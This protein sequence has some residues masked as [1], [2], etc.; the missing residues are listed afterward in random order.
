MIQD[1]V[2]DEVDHLIAAARCLKERGTYKVYVVATHGIF[3]KTAAEQLEESLIDEVRD[4]PS[5]VPRP[6]AAGLGHSKPRA[7]L[8]PGHPKLRKCRP[9]LEP[10][11]VD[12]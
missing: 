5:R 1:D 6:S 3:T 10:N 8:Q 2:I 7:P 12:T 4:T 9:L 11:L